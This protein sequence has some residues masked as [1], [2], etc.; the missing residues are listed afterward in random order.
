VRMEREVGQ[1]QKYISYLQLG[2]EFHH[3]VLEYTLF[4]GMTPFSVRIR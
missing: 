4:H 3:E 1:V 2:S